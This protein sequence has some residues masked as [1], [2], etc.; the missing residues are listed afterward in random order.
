MAG[1]KPWHQVAVP[2]EDIRKGVPLDAA[3]FAI[4]LD[5]VIDGRAPLDYREPERFFAR[6]FLTKSY[7][8]MTVEVMRRLAGDIIGTSPGIDLFRLPTVAEHPAEGAPHH[9]HFPDGI[10]Y[11]FQFLPVLQFENRYRPSPTGTIGLGKSHHVYGQVLL[12]GH[13]EHLSQ[14]PTGDRRPTDMLTSRNDDIR[15]V[16]GPI[17]QSS[18]QGRLPQRLRPVGTLEL[19]AESQVPFLGSYGV[20]AHSPKLF[21]LAINPSTQR[22]SWEA[23]G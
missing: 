22:F 20:S 8:K 23:G 5:Q 1:L 13:R 15:Q 17:A 4:H 19:A 18:R 14:V 16:L 11:G 12:L 2:R 9:A 10:G 6:T 7:R 3:E 21:R